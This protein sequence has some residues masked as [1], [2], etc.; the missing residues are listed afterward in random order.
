[1]L[2]A[3]ERSAVETAL[4]LILTEATGEY[5]YEEVT[6]KR[7]ILGD[8]GASGNCELCNENAD[9]GWI[10]MDD[11]FEGVDGDV[12]EPPAHPHCSCEVEIKDKRRRVY[13]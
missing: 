4:L 3:L 8:G 11:I 2:T 13:I 9:Q 5:Y 12:D 6:L 10:D 1:M 7:W